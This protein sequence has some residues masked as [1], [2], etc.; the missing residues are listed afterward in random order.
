MRLTLV[1]ALGAPPEGGGAPTVEPP[2]DKTPP[3]LD[4]LLGLEG[5]D[6]AEQVAEEKTRDEL[7]RRLAE[8]EAG[9]MFAEAI[10][11]MGRA[12]EQL[13]QRFDTGLGTQRVQEDILKKL[14]DLLEAAKQQQ[15]MGSPSSSG[16]SQTPTPSPN[17]GKQ[18]QGA[19]PGQQRNQ[20]P[21]S[22]QEGDPPPMQR[23]DI[24]TMLEEQRS[25]WGNLPQR[26][27]EML[28]QGRE[29]KFSSLYERLTREYYRRLAED[30]S[31]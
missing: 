28:L 29:E 1:F 17:P 4:E 25:E 6:A 5:D 21:D 23:G 13:E 27:R 19:P 2:P 12:A 30:G 22:S 18:G 16:S 9:S 8:E 14:D 10:V 7:A 24:N 20:S 15:S 11:Q 3:S 31:P 26:I